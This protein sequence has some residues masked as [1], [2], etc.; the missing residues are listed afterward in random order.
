MIT[1]TAEQNELDLLRA[2]VRARRAGEDTTVFVRALERLDEMREQDELAAAR[3][4][5]N[6]E[7]RR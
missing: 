6:G 4:K 5:L 3:R 7:R 2:Q 1:G